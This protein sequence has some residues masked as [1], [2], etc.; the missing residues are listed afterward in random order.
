MHAIGPH[1]SPRP[2]D[3]P[4][5]ATVTGYWFLDRGIGTL[6]LIAWWSSP[7]VVRKNDAMTS[8]GRK[9]PPTETMTLDLEHQGQAMVLT[10]AGDIDFATATRLRTAIGGALDQRPPVFV[11]DLSSVTFISSA[12]LSVLVETHI[13]ATGHTDYRVVSS[14]ARTTRPLQLSGLGTILALYG[15]RDDALGTT[16][17]PGPR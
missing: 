10:V 17:P 1:V 15:S 13:S 11:I 9:S 2:A 14:S 8:P 5:T 7:G 12:G 3:R 4:D 16:A 6:D